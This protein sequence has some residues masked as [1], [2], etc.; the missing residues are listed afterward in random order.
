MNQ[1]FHYTCCFT[2]KRVTRVR[3]ISPRQ[4]TLA[5]LSKECPRGCELLAALCA[6][7]QVRNFNLKQ[8]VPETNALPLDQLA[9]LI[10]II[11]SQF[12]NNRKAFFCFKAEQNH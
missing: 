3:G 10:I 1:I 8:T 9:R 5:L 4:C 6:I 7:R 12:I 2:Q 11:T